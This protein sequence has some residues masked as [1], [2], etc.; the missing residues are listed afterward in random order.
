MRFKNHQRILD[1]YANSEIFF[2][3]GGG[4]KVHSTFIICKR[5]E[6]ARVH[7]VD[8]FSFH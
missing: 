6:D 2:S 3:W 7:S 4:I 1:V 5:F 8:L